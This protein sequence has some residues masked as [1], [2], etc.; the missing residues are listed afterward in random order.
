[1]PNRRSNL[2]ASGETRPKASS[3]RVSEQPGLRGGQAIVATES[4]PAAAP[5]QVKTTR[6]V[7]AMSRTTGNQQRGG[8]RPVEE[9]QKTYHSSR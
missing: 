7:V 4:R 9:I 3:G 2:A 6:R 1:M 8:R 5:R